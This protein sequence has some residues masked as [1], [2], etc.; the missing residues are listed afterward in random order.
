M[1][2]IKFYKPSFIMILI[3]TITIFYLFQIAS[4]TSLSKIESKLL[5]KLQITTEKHKKNKKVKVSHLSKLGTQKNQNIQIVPPVLSTQNT[6]TWAA[7]S[8][9]RLNNTFATQDLNTFK[10]LHRNWNLK[11]ID[12]QLEDI[13]Q[14]MNYQSHV[15]HTEKGIRAFL[16]IFINEYQACDTDGDNS[17]SLAEFQQCMINDAYLSSISPP[18]STYA[19]YINYTFTNSSGFNA[20]LFSLLDIHN[21]GDLNFHEYMSLRLYI[22]SWRKCSIMAPYIEEINFECALEVA[23]SYRTL[24]RSTVRRIYTLSLEL[25]NN[26]NMRNIDFI[27][28]V[29]IASSVRLYGK[30]NSKEDSDLT[31]REFIL[32]LDGNYLPSRYNEDIINQI[33]K[34][35]SESDQENQGIDMVSFVFYDFFLRIFDKPPMGTI[36]NYFLNSEEFVNTFTNYLFPNQTLQEI[37]KIP[38]NN[39]TDN[40]YQ[41]YT[42]LNISNYHSESDHFLKSFLETDEKIMYINRNRFNGASKLKPFRFLSVNKKSKDNILNLIGSNQNLTFNGQQTY[43]NLFNILDNDLDG[44]INF[45]DYG[46]FIQTVYLFTKFDNFYK[47]RILAGDL[48]EKFISWSDFPI[49]S[50]QFKDR[51]K[52]FNL[53]PQDI[54][55]DAYTTLLVMRIDDFIKTVVRRSDRTTIFEYELKNIFSFVNLRY[56]PDAFLNKCLRGMDNNNIPLYDWECAFINGIVQNLKYYE[57]SMAYLTTKTRN[58]TLYNTVFVNTDPIIA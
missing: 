32:S 44:Y 58:L 21:N 43:S 22:F 36:K 54:Y 13:F 11:V 1:K 7:M 18:S 40:A 34:L 53:I 42:Y 16:Q 19:S 12:K 8:Y 41:M 10:N 37:Q 45:Y 2:F 29:L 17:L 47:G 48:Y 4:F 52:R 27:T 9:S 33:F 6:T 31:K 20:I 5:E 55:L 50:A 56:I 25:A 51:A 49:I 24:R 15:D 39:L 26:L 3:F 28:Y 23:S 35:I 46:S 38:Q 30:I 14:D 57:S